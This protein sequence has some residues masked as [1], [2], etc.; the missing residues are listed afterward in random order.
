MG[1][2]LSSTE[3]REQQ[4]FDDLLARIHDI[5]ASEKT[6]RQKVADIVSLAVDYDKVDA[7]ILLSLLYSRMAALGTNGDL[8]FANCM[9]MHVEFRAESHHPLTMKDIE[10]S[11]R[12]WLM[13]ADNNQHIYEFPSFRGCYE[14][15]DAEEEND[16]YEPATIVSL[17]K[18][19]EGFKGGS[20]ILKI[21]DM[22]RLIDTFCSRDTYYRRAYDILANLD[23][24]VLESLEQGKFEEWIYVDYKDFGD[25]IFQFS[26]FEIDLREPDSQY[27][28]LYVVYRYDTIVS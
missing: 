26:H 8:R 11:Q 15:N 5:R 13:D 24:K 19:L 1:V 17:P 14:V 25:A 18:E 20:M 12:E 3:D 7:R 28:T 21:E 4:Y 9:I 10:T 27:R 16:T 2:T 23:K 6:P 22:D